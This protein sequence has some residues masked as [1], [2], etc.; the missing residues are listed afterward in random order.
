MGRQ[1]RTIATPLTWE[2][3]MGGRSKGFLGQAA[4]PGNVRCA[5][6]WVY[7]AKWFAEYN[8]NYITLAHRLSASCDGS[9]PLRLCI[10]SST[11]LPF[12]F[13]YSPFFSSLQEIKQTFFANKHRQRRV[14]TWDGCWNR[15]GRSPKK[16]L[17]CSVARDRNLLRIRLALWLVIWCVWCFK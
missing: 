15:L 4:L 14:A 1:A 5:T 9:L 2:L 13:F 8:N 10:R 7:L 11:F 17:L 3:V 16:S 12:L 6:F